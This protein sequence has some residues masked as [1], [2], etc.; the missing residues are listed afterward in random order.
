MKYRIPVLVMFLFA[1]GGTALADN[2]DEATVTV[3]GTIIQA[4]EITETTANIAMPDLVGPDTGLTSSVTL[5]CGASDA[6]N[7]VTYSGNGNPFADGTPSAASPSSASSNITLGN[8][9]GTCAVLNISGEPNFHYQV[10]MGVASGAIPTG[11]SV[12][13]FT[14]WSTVG[15]VVLTNGVAQ[16]LNGSGEDVLRCGATVTAD[17]TVSVGAYSGPHFALTVTYD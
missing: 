2:T 5:E 1:G 7:N 4:L 14:C 8:E 12:T 10:A 9:T 11:L 16:A 3:T 6:T 13:G 15:A 17:E